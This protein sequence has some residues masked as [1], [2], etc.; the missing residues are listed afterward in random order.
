MSDGDATNPLLDALVLYSGRCSLVA[1]LI[2]RSLPLSRRDSVFDINCKGIF[3]CCKYAIP[4]MLKQ[5]YGRIV[6]IASIAGK[7]GNVSLEFGGLPARDPA[8]QRPLEALLGS[9]SNPLVVQQ[10]GM[11][12]YSSSKAA[13]IGLTKVIGKELAET[14]VTCNA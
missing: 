13:V 8:R 4:H 2:P 10:A 5:K 12:A 7:E 1:R 9:R 3:L 14:G 6:N 11:L